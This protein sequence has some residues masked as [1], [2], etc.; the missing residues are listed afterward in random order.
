MV[1]QLDKQLPNAF[2]A[3][4]RIR[5][6]NYLEFDVHAME[7]ELPQPN[8]VVDPNL[9]QQYEYEVLV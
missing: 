8:H 3:E 2:A 1:L 6:G 4:P 9:A 7:R 5:L